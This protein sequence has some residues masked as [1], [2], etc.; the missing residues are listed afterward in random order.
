MSLRAKRLQDIYLIAMSNLTKATHLKKSQIGPK[1]LA[2][3][4]KALIEECPNMN[5]RTCEELLK[6]A[7][8]LDTL[9]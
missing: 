1:A 9:S 4:T 7:S 5:S 8:E 2:E 6:I 3:Y